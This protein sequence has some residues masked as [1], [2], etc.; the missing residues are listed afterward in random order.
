MAAVRMVQ[1]HLIFTGLGV[2]PQKP[3]LVRR[4]LNIT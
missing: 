2:N 4:T 3:L 1:L